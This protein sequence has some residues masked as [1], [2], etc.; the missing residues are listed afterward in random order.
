M[1]L[2]KG[3]SPFFRTQW[4]RARKLARQVIAEETAPRPYVPVRAQAPELG[5]REY[6]EMRRL[7][8]AVATAFPAKRL[9]VM[10]HTTEEHVGRVLDMD[11]RKFQETYVQ[12]F[13]QRMYLRTLS[14]RQQDDLLNE[15]RTLRSRSRFLYDRFVKAKQE[16]AA[17]RGKVLGASA[18]H[19]EPAQSHYAPEVPVQQTEL[20]EMRRALPDGDAFMDQGLR[21]HKDD[22]TVVAEYDF[23]RSFAEFRAFLEMHPHVRELGYDGPQH[24]HQ[25]QHQHQQPKEGA[26]EEHDPASVESTEGAGFAGGAQETLVGDRA[27]NDGCESPQRSEASAFRDDVRSFF[28]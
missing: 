8:R 12:P 27:H 21:V 19:T 16:C 26:E 20:A 17:Q 14:F 4:A 3:Q 15:F 9:A 6:A 11:E 23:S 22:R 7:H 5:M 13:L 25:H 18:V 10:Y 2:L 1:L 28:Q 24:Q